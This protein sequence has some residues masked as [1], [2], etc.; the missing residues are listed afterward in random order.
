MN[1]EPRI[2]ETTTGT[3]GGF[4]RVVVDAKAQYFA[5][6]APSGRLL[7]LD[8]AGTEYR[9]RGACFLRFKASQVNA[10]IVWSGPI[11]EVSEHPHTGTATGG[12][13]IFH[14]P[15]ETITVDVRTELLRTIFSPARPSGGIPQQR[16]TYVYPRSV[17]ELS[18][19]RLCR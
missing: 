19:P 12:T 17:P 10:Q 6:Y 3:V 1:A 8:R 15:S 16:G 4:G 2:I 18:A 5:A 9:R 7:V 14:S 11:R 13:A